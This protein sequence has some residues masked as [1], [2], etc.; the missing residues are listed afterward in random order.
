MN[1][2]PTGAAFKVANINGGESRMEL[3]KQ[4]AARPHDQK[5]LSL[6]ALENHVQTRASRCKELRAENRAIEFLAPDVE[7]IEDTHKLTLGLPD[8]TEVAPT[9]WAFGQLANLAGAPAAYLKTLPSQIVA[10]A[11]TFGMR[12]NRKTDQLKAFYDPDSMLA[13]TGPEYGRI[14]DHEV[15]AAVRQIAGDGTGDTAWKVPGVMDWRTMIYDPS[16]PITLDTTTLYASD[17][18]VFIFLVD[19]THPIVIGKTKNGEDD[20]V[21][22]GWYIT[23]SEVGSSALKLAVFYLRAICCNRIM[24]GVEGFEEMTIRHTR[25]APARFVEVARPT[26]EAFS[27]GSVKSFT[28][29]VQRA[30]AAIVAKDEE[31]AIEFLKERSFS[32]KKAIDILTRVQDEEGRPARTAWDMA[33]GITALARDVPFMDERFAMEAVAGKILDKAVPRSGSLV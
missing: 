32:R 9:N 6:S 19:D 14:Y 21:F 29:G 25:Y 10:D 16:A 20:I 4:W 12:A 27:R 8:G 18:D 7:T 23:N 1:D 24:W 17:R 13:A 31:A 11:L 5:F 3:S 22:R 28:E 33:Q 15:V 26:L 30:Q 2:M